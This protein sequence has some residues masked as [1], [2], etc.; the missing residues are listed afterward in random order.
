MPPRPILVTGATGRAGRHVV[1]QLLAKDVAVRALVRNPD[2]A[3]LPPQVEVFRGDLTRPETLDTCLDGIDAVFLVWVA[4]VDSAAPVIERI[5]KRARRIVFLSSPHKTPHPLFQAANP[6][7][8]SQLHEEIERLIQASGLEWTFLRPGMFAANALWWWASQIR[9][10]D[11]VRWPYALAPS[12]PIDESDIAAVAV[13]ALSNPTSVAA[14]HVLTGPE[15][16]TH[17]DQVSL[18]GDVLGRT[19]RYE[20]ITPEDWVEPGA[21]MLLTAWSAAIGHPALITPT[22]AEITGRPPRT[23]RDWVTHNAEKF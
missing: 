4:P 6:N 14:E 12:A 1:A 9:A 8:V 23:F 2:T 10:G 20:E 19:L 17:A 7:P 11:V 13:H 3:G 22:V 18:I 16:L 15:S 21:N 5:A